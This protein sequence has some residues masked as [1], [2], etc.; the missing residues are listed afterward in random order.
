MQARWR[1]QPT[2]FWSDVPFIRMAAAPTTSSTRAQA[3]RPHRPYRTPADR[4]ALWPAA[5]QAGGSS[6]YDELEVAFAESLA[7]AHVVGLG[8]NMAELEANPVLGERVIRDLNS[9]RPCRSPTRVSTARSARCRWRPGEALRG[10]AEIAR[11][12]KPGGG[13]SSPSRTAGSRPSDQH[14][15]SCHEF[16]R[17]GIVLEYFLRS[18]RSRTSRPFRARPAPP[19]DDKYAGQFPLSD[20]STRCGGAAVSNGVD[21]YAYMQQWPASSTP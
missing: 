2:D 8:M 15:Q 11:V 9:T 3:G 10:V 12:L 7:P 5:A 6:T 18:G 17:M 19:E 4:A 21:P 14:L 20:P 16:E 13:S 1:N